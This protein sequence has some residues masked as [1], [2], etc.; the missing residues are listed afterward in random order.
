M[1][2]IAFYTQGTRELGTD[3]HIKFP[4]S[5]LLVFSLQIALG[6]IGFYIEGTRELGMHLLQRDN[7]SEFPVPSG[8]NSAMGI[9]LK[10]A[11]THPVAARADGAQSQ[12]FP[13]S[14][15]R[16]RAWAG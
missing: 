12:R 8:V 11:E 1:G 10:A 5:Q 3:T 2:I 7:H 15:E 6:L 13:P 16:P 4:S 14:R 9:P